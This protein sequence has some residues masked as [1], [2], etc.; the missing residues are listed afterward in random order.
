MEQF[1]LTNITNDLTRIAIDQTVEEIKLIAQGKIINGFF[2]ILMAIAT[3]TGAKYLKPGKIKITLMIITG[4]LS[5][6]GIINLVQAITTAAIQ[7][8]P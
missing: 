8:V 1:L 7:V 4:I 2:K 5:I 3:G 6:W